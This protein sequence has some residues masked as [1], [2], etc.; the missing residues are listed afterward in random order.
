MAN[1]SAD[2]FLSYLAFLILFI[3]WLFTFD[4]KPRLAPLRLSLDFSFF[5]NCLIMPVLI[6]DLGTAAETLFFLWPLITL[7]FF[8]FFGS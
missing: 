2:D 6:F 7:I 5:I 3:L 8:K 1:T 4:I